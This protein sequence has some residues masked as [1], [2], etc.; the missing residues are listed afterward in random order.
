VG[1]RFETLAATGVEVTDGVGIEGAYGGTART[2]DMNMD[3]ARK[4]VYK[5]DGL[6]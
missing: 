1:L 5:A 4:S 6:R 2:E 3:Q